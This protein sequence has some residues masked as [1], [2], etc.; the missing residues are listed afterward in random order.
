MFREI[1][2]SVT[3]LATA[4]SAEDGMRA[5]EQAT[6]VKSL[7]RLLTSGPTFDCSKAKSPLA[8]TICSDQYAA[9]TDWELSSA[10][11]A[12]YFSKPDSASAQLRSSH[13]EWLDQLEFRCLLQSRPATLSA[14]PIAAALR[15]IA[16]NWRAPL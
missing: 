14:M 9:S 1:I 6:E 4:A 8:L 15:Y 2:I 3:I 16:R 5:L 12:L 11:L 7:T 13:L 10:Y